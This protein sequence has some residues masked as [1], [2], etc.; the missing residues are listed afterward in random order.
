MKTF[1]VRMTAIALIAAQLSSCGLILYPER[2]DQRK[3]GRID[4]AVAILDG[5][6]CLFFLIPGLIAF[7]VDFHEG[8][9]YLP[10]GETA[11]APGWRRVALPDGRVTDA[12]IEQA[13]REQTGQQVTLDDPRLE[14]Y[15][16]DDLDPLIV[17]G[18]Y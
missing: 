13:L 7:A 9:I 17:A 11:D 2:E 14:A 12:A 8:T 4:P 15:R 3:S 16:V 10:P 1:L 6:G 5:V 18:Q